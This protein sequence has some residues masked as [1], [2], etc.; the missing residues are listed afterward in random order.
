M[1]TIIRRSCLQFLKRINHRM[2]P[3]LFQNFIIFCNRGLQVNWLYLC[4]E[5]VAPPRLLSSVQA[6]KAT[7][8]K[9]ASVGKVANFML[10]LFRLCRKAVPRFSPLLVIWHWLCHQPAGAVNNL[11]VI[12]E[13]DKFPELRVPRASKVFVA[14]LV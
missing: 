12:S 11:A 9:R 3:C 14:Y 4:S 8:W 10:R 6:A 5:S 2:L 13:L 1:L 7:L